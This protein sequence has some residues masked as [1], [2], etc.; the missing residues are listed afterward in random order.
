MHAINLAFAKIPIGFHTVNACIA[1]SATCVLVFFLFRSM[2]GTIVPFELVFLGILNNIICDI[3][4][5]MIKFIPVK[6]ERTG[7]TKRWNIGTSKLFHS[8]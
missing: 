6:N 5:G 8:L 2:T 3:L 7:Q 1:G 4:Y